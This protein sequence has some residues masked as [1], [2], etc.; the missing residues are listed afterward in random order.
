[1]DAAPTESAW[2]RIRMHLESEMRRVKEE[3][4]NYPAPIPACDAQYNHLLDAREALTTELSRL[5]DLMGDD[6]NGVSIDA[7]LD[8]CT[9]LDDAAKRA[10]RVD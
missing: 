1:M 10:L 3:I 8:G 5:R 7:F 2:T 6:G 4:R 9:V